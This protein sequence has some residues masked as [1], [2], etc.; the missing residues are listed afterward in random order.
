MDGSLVRAL[1]SNVQG[2]GFNLHPSHC[3][4][5]CKQLRTSNNEVLMLPLGIEPTTLLLGGERLDQYANQWYDREG[6]TMT[7]LPDVTMTL[8]T[9]SA[10]VIVSPQTC[11]I[12]KWWQVASCTTWFA[13]ALSITQFS[14]LSTYGPCRSLKKVEIQVFDPIW[15]S[16]EGVKMMFFKQNGLR[17]QSK[18]QCK[19]NP[20]FLEGIK[21]TEA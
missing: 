5:A 3:F 14:P 9:M 1:D 2:R 20:P 16:M 12:M 13:E 19:N 17:E 18:I 4:P 10:M 6:G 7:D 15:P 21:H 11:S 8:S